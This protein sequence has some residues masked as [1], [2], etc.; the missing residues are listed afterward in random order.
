MSDGISAGGA[1]APSASTGSTASTSTASTPSSSVNSG[2]N[3]FSANNSSGGNPNASAN[4]ATP[5][6]QTAP[7]APAPRK[8][9]DAD[10]DAIVSVD[11]NG[12]SQEMSVRELKKLQQLERVSRQKMSEAA[13]QAQKSQAIVQAIQNGDAGAFKQLTGLDLDQ[14]TEAHLAKKYEMMQMSPEQRELME[15]RQAKEQQAK[16]EQQSKQEVAKEIAQLG[17]EIP[18]EALKNATKEQ[19]ANFLQEKRQQFQAEEQR[20]QQEVIGAWEKTGLPKDKY[21]GSMMSYEMMTF[22]KRSGEPLQAEKA[23]A[24]VKNK[25]VNNVREIVSK[26]DAPAIQEMLGKEIVQM[27]RDYDVQRVTGQAASNVASASRQGFTPANG[28]KSGKQVLNQVEWRK[29]MGIE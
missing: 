7:A 12:Q 3:S 23:A 16:L 8:L 4:P 24:I 14:Y 19:L 21:F 28:A 6:G 29:A 25:F 13:K 27:L 20:L 18:E 22:Q 9:S 17:I 26:M 10:L 2:S 15:L 1:S 5:Q 11:I